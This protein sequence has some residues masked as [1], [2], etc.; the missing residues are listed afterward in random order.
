[1]A[2]TDPLVPTGAVRSMDQVLSHSLAL[3]SFM[4]MLLSIFGGLA[5]VLASVGIYG[6]ISYAVS[7]RTREIGV[8]MA[9]GARPADV[10][11][12]ILSEGL[13]LVAVGVALGLVAA[14]MLTRLLEGMVY[15]VSMRD[16]LIFVLVNLLLVTVSLAA[17]YVP[18]RRA[19][20]VDP[21]VALRYE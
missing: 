2:A 7:Q 20:R 6:V 11:R 5:L 1:V 4:M 19:M 9:L 21:L 15:G 13:K 16:P 8:R 17:C 18:A 10:L 14:L 12:M 3:R